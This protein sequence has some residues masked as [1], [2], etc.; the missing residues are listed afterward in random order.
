MITHTQTHTHIPLSLIYLR[1]QM[2][3]AQ[4]YTEACGLVSAPF[5]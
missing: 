2:V 3:L 4:E 5:T 1:T